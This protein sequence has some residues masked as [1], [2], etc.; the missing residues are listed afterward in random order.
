MIDH[1]QLIAS[2]IC[3]VANFLFALVVHK[4][5]SGK[6]ARLASSEAAVDDALFEVSEKLHQLLSSIVKEMNEKNGKENL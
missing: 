4:R 3:S 6:I 2:L 5:S 1:W